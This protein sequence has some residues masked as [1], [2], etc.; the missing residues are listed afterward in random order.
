MKLLILILA[1]DTPEY[2]QM[3][4][5]WKKY[6][7]LFENIKSY[8]IKYDV[9]KIY[10]KNIELTNDTIFIKGD[11]DSFIPGCLDKTIKAIEYA[12][13]NIEFDYLLRTNMSSVW[14]L[15]KFHTLVSNND[16]NVAGVNGYKFVSGAGILMAKSVCSNIIINKHLL[17]YSLID[18]VSIGHLLIELNYSFDKLTRFEAFV[19]K[20]PKDITQDLIKNNYHFRCKSTNQKKTIILMEKIIKLIYNL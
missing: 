6:M 17:D 19:Y 8:F 1:N 10:N 4:N 14:D 16:W 13:A 11:T 15:N 3:Q 9:E 2:L 20:N 18:D 7:G 12:L 5:L